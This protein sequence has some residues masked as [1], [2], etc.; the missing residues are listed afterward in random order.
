MDVEDAKYYLEHEDED[1]D[2]EYLVAQI[3]SFEFSVNTIANGFD[4][5]HNEYLELKE[6]AKECLNVANITLSN[7]YNQIENERSDVENKHTDIVISDVEDCTGTYM[8]T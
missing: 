8:W 3:N 1:P 2:G 4:D 5:Y 6:E 7:L